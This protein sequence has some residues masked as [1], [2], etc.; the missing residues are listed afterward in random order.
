MYLPIVT[1]GGCISETNHI[2]ALGS[3]LTGTSRLSHLWCSSI[4][5]RTHSNACRHF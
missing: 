4:H 3:Q 1:K 5:P 2:D